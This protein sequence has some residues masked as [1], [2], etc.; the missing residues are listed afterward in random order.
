MLRWPI[1][2][3]PG[4]CVALLASPAP[5]LAGD[6]LYTCAKAAPDAKLTIPFTPDRTLHDLGVWVTG[7]TCKSVVYD[8]EA[9]AR[10]TKLALIAPSSVTPKQAV[11]LFVDTVQKAGLAVAEKPDA[12]VISL[13]PAVALRCPAPPSA[14][15]VGTGS[16]ACAPA[17][18]GTKLAISMKPDVTL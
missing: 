10:A 18:A 6:P 12:F 3:G 16:G 13:P 5:A 8:S 11:Q 4:L 17:A 2:A 1:L 15:R 14:P 7:F 9:A